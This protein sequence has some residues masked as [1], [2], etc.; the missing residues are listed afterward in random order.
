MNHTKCD[1]KIMKELKH[2]TPRS[3]AGEQA[4]VR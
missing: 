4:W 1:I 3:K 2:V